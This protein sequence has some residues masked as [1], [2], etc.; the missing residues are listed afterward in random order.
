MSSSKR[1]TSLKQ[2]SSTLKLYVSLN[3]FEFLTF[4]LETKSD[5]PAYYTNRAIAYLKLDNFQGAMDDCKI[6]GFHL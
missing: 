5:E 4:N 6:T 2:L 1:R 3:Q